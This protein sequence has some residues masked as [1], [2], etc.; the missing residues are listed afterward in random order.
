MQSI[1]ADAQVYFTKRL[2]NMSF[3][4]LFYFSQSML[5]FL[6]S[7]TPFI[8]HVLTHSF[9]LCEV[10]SSRCFPRRVYNNVF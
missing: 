4:V 2:T 7:L 6:V 9:S 3:N 5:S 10:W 8:L 1:G